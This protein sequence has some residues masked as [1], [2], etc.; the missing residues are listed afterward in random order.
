MILDLSDYGKFL[1]V[2]AFRTPQEMNPTEFLKEL[3][4]R[5]PSVEL[6]FFDCNHVAGIEHL[7]MAAINALHAFRNSINVSRS[8]SMETLLYASAQRQIDVA[9]QMVGV[10]GDCQ[11]VGFVA[12]S[13]TKDAAE[14]LE[15]KIARAIATE[16]DISLL[17]EWSDEKADRI[18]DMYGI[19]DA[20][21]EA[22]RLPGLKLKEVISKAIVE[23]VALLS[24]RT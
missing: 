2:S 14:S 4:A 1:T 20:E 17:E 19:K 8:L 7:E 9:I 5:L 22:L 3:R 15:N 18:R 21:L 23:R 11:C 10:T 13:E 12:F 16:L 24:T 6:Q